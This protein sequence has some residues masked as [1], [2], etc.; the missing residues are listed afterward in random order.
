VSRQPQPLKSIGSLVLVGAG[1]MGTA[2]L[3]GWLAQG[4]NAKKLIVIEPLPAKS[5]KA[6]ARRGVKLNPKPGPKAKADAGAIIVAV[7][8]QTAPDAVP[9]IGLYVG[10]STLVLSI[11]AGRT[12][13]FLE[14]SLP[15]GTAIVRAMPNTPAA[16]GR[17]TTVLC[18]NAAADEAA[19]GMAE[20]LMSA[21]G[22]IHW[23]ED[24]EL[25]HAVTALSGGGPAYVF[26]LIEALAAAGARAGLPAEM[27]ARLARSTVTGSAEL[28][29]L[30][31]APS[32]QLRRD[33]TSPRGTTEAA[34]R[35]LM[36]EDGLP[37]LMERAIAAAAQRSRELA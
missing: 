37:A 36:A 31:P 23:V 2:M 26:L 17:G 34:L 25:M 24:E 10:K 22:E 14:N 21:V 7:K 35:V 12:I 33:V 9:P 32:D 30:S 28:A 13:G 11:M 15:P 6:L 16:V 18:A 8:P 19:R 20:D 29:R 1:K 27:A 4:L 3:D 5:L